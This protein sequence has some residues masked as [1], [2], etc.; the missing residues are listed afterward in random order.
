MARRPISLRATVALAL[1]L[2]MPCACHE[3]LQ[4][5]SDFVADQW[6]AGALPIAALL[7]LSE[8]AGLSARDAVR[9]AADDAGA[10]LNDA[11]FA[12]LVADSA[13]SRITGGAG[14]ETE[15]RRRL[16]LL[17]G[18]GAPAVVVADGAATRVA[19]A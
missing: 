10:A 12:T 3:D 11:V 13:P 1:T 5:P 15:L 19:P 4:H 2:A 9:L 16:A 6:V 7:P 8:G 14:I 18:A 17:R